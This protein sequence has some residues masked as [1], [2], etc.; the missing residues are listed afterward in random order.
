MPI[1]VGRCAFP[2]FLILV[3]KFVLLVVVAEKKGLPR[4]CLR[5]KICAHVN[6]VFPPRVY[7]GETQNK[8]T[9]LRREYLIRFFYM[10]VNICIYTKT[11]FLFVLRSFNALTAVTTEHTCE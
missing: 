11:F 9:F 2:F 8:M 10:Y 3:G 5:S 7:G 1:V 4:V 6:V